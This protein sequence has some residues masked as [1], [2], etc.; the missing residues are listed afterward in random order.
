MDTLG[1]NHFF[2]KNLMLMLDSFTKYL[3][4]SSTNCIE[5]ELFL[6]NLVKPQM[7]RDNKNTLWRLVSTH[8][9]KEKLWPGIKSFFSSLPLLFSTNLTKEDC[10]TGQKGIRIGFYFETNVPSVKLPSMVSTL[11]I[12]WL[13]ETLERRLNPALCVL[14]TY[15][16]ISL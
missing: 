4:N 13:P 14:Q 8:C 3:S 11:Y 9:N 12:G 7:H 10:H 16:R 15:F 6:K 5:N 2:E 1:W